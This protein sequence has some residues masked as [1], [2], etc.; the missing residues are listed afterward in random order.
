MIKQQKY[1]LLLNKKLLF[2]WIE[3]K[4]QH[5]YLALSAILGVLI[6]YFNL[7]GF[8]LIAAGLYICYILLQKNITVVIVSFLT[9][10]GFW[11]LFVV[12]EQANYSRLQPTDTNFTFEIIS[13]VHSDGNKLST[14]IKTSS[15]EKLQLNYYV[16]SLK[17]RKSLA[18]LS[19]GDVCRVSGELSLPNLARNPNGFDY[20]SYLYKKGIHWVFQ[21]SAWNVNQCKEGEFDLI[22]W[23]L[24]QRESGIRQVADSFPDD[25]EGIIQALIF[26]ERKQIE[27]DVT[28]S[29][30]ALGIVHLLAISGLHVGFITTMLFYLLVRFGITREKAVVALL[31]FLPFYIV[32]AGGAPSVSRACMMT[33][34]LLT[35][36][37]WKNRLSPVDAISIACGLLLLYNPYLLFEVGFQLSFIVSFSLIMSSTL[38]LKQGTVITTLAKV[39]IIAQLSG[40]PVI[41]FNFYEISLISLPLNMVFVPFYSILILPLTITAFLTVGLFEPLGNFLILILSNLLRYTN[42]IVLWI[43]E[44]FTLTITFGKPNVFLLILYII[45]IFLLFVA[46]ETKNKLKH[47]V[48]LFLFTCTIHYFS[49]YLNPFGEVTMLDIGQG[50]TIYIK[51]PFRK[52]VYLIDVT[53]RISFEDE[54]WKKKNH[55]FSVSQDVVVPFLKSK[56]VRSIDQ[57]IL[58]HGDYDHMGGAIDLMEQISTS[59]IILGQGSSENQLEKDLIKFAQNKKIRISTVKEGDRWKVGHHL[60]YVLAP[61]ETRNKTENNQSVVIYTMLGGQKW[62]FTG[63]LEREGEQELVNR[64]PKLEVD[65]LKVGHHGSN[66]STTQVFLEHFNPKTGIISV[67]QNNRYGHPHP[68]L[69]DRL[70]AASLNIY[71]TDLNG[72]I[73]FKFSKK[74]GTFSVV[75][76]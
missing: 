26:G 44:H 55:A 31:S 54:D 62:L 3:L 75:I 58:T 25:V 69:I 28:K 37:K 30:Q 11:C 39:T 7:N 18:S 35:S 10:I 15:D 53:E 70:Q 47:S 71:R 64:Y 8:L 36:A 59:M 33:A 5:I 34:L 43:Y 49:P 21:P 22:T 56:G 4:G 52:A 14:T 72:A 27:E 46:W 66:T 48:L 13:P 38:I 40:L 63:D 6:P 74:K 45:S 16:E 24:K 57:L 17:Q 60:F 76:P 23:I 51:L 29:Y 12:T 65:V 50:D 32:I 20:Q 2:C 41:L 42:H 67:G 19:V 61:N 73:S 9:I 68:E 1:L